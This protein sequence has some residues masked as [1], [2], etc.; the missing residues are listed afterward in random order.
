MA[1]EIKDEL[2][3]TA[4]RRPE[5]LQDYAGAANVFDDA[6]LEN[7]RVIGLGDIVNRISNAYFEERPGSQINITIRG[8]GTFTNGS[9]TRTDSA[10]GI[11]YDGIYSYIQGSRIPLLYYDLDRIEV[12]KGPQGGLY[13]RN[14]VGGAVIAHTA[15]PKDEFS[16]SANLEY[17][18]Y[19]NISIPGPH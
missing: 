1:V 13:G 18:N 15:T 12:F 10:I 11:Y 16:A 6:A 19:E 3:V 9:A 8:A 5:L 7:A 14:A 2:I 4:R 17:G